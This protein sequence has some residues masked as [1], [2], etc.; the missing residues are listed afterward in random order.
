[1]A[2]DFEL[3]AGEEDFAFVEVLLEGREEGVAGGF[4][5]H[6]G[7]EDFG[8]AR[9]ERGVEFRTADEVDIFSL[10]RGGDFLGGTED[11]DPGNL[12]RARENPVF[13]AGEGLSDGVVSFAAHENDMAERRAFE[14]FQI[15]GEMPRN[16]AIEADGAVEGHRGDGDHIDIGA[17]MAGWGS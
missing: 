3:V 4:E 13:T 10:G 1:M 9:E 8:A 15:L 7:E 12:G 2:A 14:K 17:L 6:A 16:A 11:L 5:V